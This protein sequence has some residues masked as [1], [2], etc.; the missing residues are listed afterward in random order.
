M[1]SYLSLFTNKAAD[2]AYNALDYGLLPDFAVR[3]AIRYLC[4]Q[5]LD[6]IAHTDLAAAAEHKWAYVEDMKR[7]P[8]AIEQ[9]RANEQHYHVA[10]PFMASCLGKRMKYSC[11]LY[12]TGKETLDEAEVLM[13]E[14][15]CDKAKLQDGLEILD[16][17]CGWGSLSLFLG[18]VSTSPRIRLSRVVR[19]PPWGQR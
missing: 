4:R 1:S 7:R 18:E 12:P 5:R 6:E 14:S 10:T 19:Q 8:I 9:D 15:Y 16:L 11:C 13:L 3:R 2:S 17:G